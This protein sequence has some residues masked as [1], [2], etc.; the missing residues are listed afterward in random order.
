MDSVHLEGSG[1][2]KSNQQA[3]WEAFTGRVPLDSIELLS[4]SQSD[5]GKSLLINGIFLT[6]LVKGIQAGEGPDTPTFELVYPPRGSGS[7]PFIYSWRDDELI[8]EGEAIGIALGK[9]REMTTTTVLPLLDDHNEELKIRIS[10]E[11]PESHLLNKISLHRVEIDPAANVVSDNNQDLWPVYAKEEPLTATDGTG[12]NIKK[13]I[14]EIDGIYW[15]SDLKN[16]SMDYEDTLELTFKR[17]AK[18]CQGSLIIRAIN[19]HFGNYVFDKLFE[20]LGNQ[21]LQ[22]MHEIENNPEVIQS[23][24]N[25]TYESALKASVWNHSNWQ[26]S[27]IVNPEANMTPFTR[28]IRFD[29]PAI[30]GDEIK[31][32][33]KSLADVWKIDAIYMDWTEVK[34]LEKMEL[35][36]LSVEGNLSMNE[37]HVIEKNDEHYAVLMPSQFIDLTYGNQKASEEKKGCFALDVSGYLYEWTPNNYGASLFSGI[38]GL[39]DH[40]RVEFVRQLLDHR[41]ILLPPLYADW[42]M[43]KYKNR[44]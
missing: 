44:N 15:Q 37:T 13:Q 3:K 38:S 8:L 31:I 32:R 30:T 36:R 1:R 33:L 23:L 9:A 35:P 43:F 19:T 22:F 20:L 26:N 28:L 41:E 34:K 11:R 10:N 21:S 39:D 7:C 27:G 42:I 40:K 12:N 17:P 5:F 24:E 25:W 2:I 4:F 29:I 6:L 14:L 18:A 16:L